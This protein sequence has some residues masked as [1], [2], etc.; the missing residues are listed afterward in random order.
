VINRLIEAVYNSALNIQTS[1]FTQESIM[2]IPLFRSVS[3]SVYVAIFIAASI[4]QTNAQTNAQ[5]NGKTVSL[6]SPFPAGGI[7]DLV[8]R[9]IAPSL[10]KAL[11]QTVIVENVTGANGSIAA[12]KMFNAPADGHVLMMVSPGETIMPP[13]LMSSVKFKAEDFR[14]LV[15][16][17]SVPLALLMRPGLNFKNVDELITYAKNPANK[18]LSFGSFGNGSLGHLAAAH[19]IELTGAKMIHVPYRGGAPLTTDLMGDQIDLSFFPIAGNGLQ[20]VDSGKVKQLGIAL[21]HKLPQYAKYDLLSAHPLLKPFVH[22]SWQSIAVPRAVPLALA[23]KLNQDLNLIFQSEDIKG[24]ASKNGSFIPA[25]LGL[26]QI[27][28]NYQAEIARTRALAKAV[29]LEAQ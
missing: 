18:P 23:E 10:S 2:A 28:A 14:L 4:G 22:L 21:D 15:N 11:S 5:T 20:M 26:A 13:I 25:P 19:F 3:K 27:E 17:P 16:G 1:L 24:L 7:T 8:A 12:N 29:K 6:V 9:A